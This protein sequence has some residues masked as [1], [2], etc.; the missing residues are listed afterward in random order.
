MPIETLALSRQDYD[1][2]AEVTKMHPSLCAALAKTTRQ[3]NPA[4]QLEVGV[5]QRDF[6]NGAAAVRLRPTY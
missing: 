5:V 2:Y 4:R 6:L 1:P 3:P